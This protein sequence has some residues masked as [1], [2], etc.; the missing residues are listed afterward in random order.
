MLK[1]IAKQILPSE[2]SLNRKQGF[3]LPISKFIKDKKV[4]TLIKDVLLNRDCIF[5]QDF[6]NKL[7]QSLD[8]K[9]KNEERILGLLFFEIWRKKNNIII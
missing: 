6:V 7:I 5:N 2:F 3:S 4:I 9:R 1:E 8:K